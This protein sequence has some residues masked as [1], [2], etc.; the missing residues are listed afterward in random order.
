MNARRDGQPVR[1]ISIEAMRDGQ[2]RSREDLVVV[3]E[4]LEIRLARP[5]EPG[6]GRPISITMR[7]PGQ[8]QG[9]AVGFL[10]DRSFNVDTHRERLQ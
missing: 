5:A 9:L 7:T 8:D 6:L 10:R 2:L 1:Q 3:E 4:P